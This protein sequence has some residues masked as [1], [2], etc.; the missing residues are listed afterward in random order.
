MKKS[1]K[2]KAQ[3]ADRKSLSYRLAKDWSMNKWKYIMILPV[4]IYLILFCYKPMYGLVIAF[5]NYKLTRGIDGSPWVSPWY[6]WF[7][8]FFEDP[9]FWRLIKNTFVLS[10]LTI[11]FG[12]PAPIILALLL[13]EIKSNKFKRV[14]QT[15][16][17]MPYFISM[18]VMCSIIK[19][20]CQQ[21]GLFSTIV[22]A[23]GGTGQNYLMNGAYF[24]L[25]YVLSD[26]WQGIG[27]NSIIYLAALTSIDQQLYEAAKVDGANR[28]QLMTHV[29][30]PGL[31]P[32]IVVMFIL[33]M[34]NIVNIGY[35]KIL[36]LYN[37]SIYNVSD[38]IST[39]IYRLSF[40]TSGMPLYSK[41]TAIGLFNSLINV[42]FL[43]FT[44]WLSKK[45]TESS[46]F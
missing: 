41:A 21:N 32:T 10:G 45:T 3:P 28:W 46:L 26:I 34:G 44:N 5:K 23:F 7:Q 6:Y 9:Y 2:S 33:R 8:N 24:P 36:L 4:V 22:E 14:V 27:W 29:T 31:M 40:P 15:I 16:T 42:V 35:E 1:T 39:Y 17:Y 18:V 30:L 37:P 19:I 11:L 20:F 13:N 38:V 43:L 25:I 12:F